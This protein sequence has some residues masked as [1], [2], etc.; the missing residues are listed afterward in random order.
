MFLRETCSFGFPSDLEVSVLQPFSRIRRDEVRHTQYIAQLGPI[1]RGE[2]EVESAQL[3]LKLAQEVG[4]V[5][6]CAQEDEVR[7]YRA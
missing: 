7:Q 5:A 4:M 2:A 6:A 1:C 3:L